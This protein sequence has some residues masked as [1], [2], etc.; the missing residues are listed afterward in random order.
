MH[1]KDGMHRTS[2]TRCKMKLHERT[3]PALATLTSLC[4]YA[5][6]KTIPMVS[7]HTSGR[8]PFLPDKNAVNPPSR[9]AL[10]D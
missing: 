7:L 8:S 5:R 3:L 1:G 9:A 6:K 2:I 10:V 4:G